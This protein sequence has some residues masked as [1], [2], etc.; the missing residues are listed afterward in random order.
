[1]VHEVRAVADL[2]E[3]VPVVAVVQVARDACALGLPVEPGAERAVVDA[4]AAD[5]D[6]DR[7]VQLDAGDLVAVELAL[8]GD[9]VDVVVLDRGEH[10][11][12]VADDAFL[13]AVEDRVAPD[14]VRADVLAVPADLAGGEHGLELVLVAGF[15]AAQR[16]VIVACRGLLAERDSRAPRV[17]DRV[18][19]D[20]PALGPVRADEPGLVRGR[21]GPRARRLGQFEAAYGDVVE[22]VLGRIEHRPAHVDLHQFGVRV[23]AA[24]VRPDRRRVVADLGVPD[25]AG[26]PGVA[27]P[28]GH[29]GPVVGDLG[30]QWRIGHLVAGTH[31]I[32]ATAVQVDIAEVLDGR[33][34]GLDQPVARNL[35]REGIPV[36][37]HRVGHR[38]PPHRVSGAGA[39]GTGAPGTGAPG[40]GARI[41]L[42]ARDR[43]RPLDHHVLTRRGLVGDAPRPAQ[44][45]TPRPHPLRYTPPVNQHSIAR[46][47]ELSRPADRPQRT[48]RGTVRRIRTVNRHMQY[49]HRPQ[50]SSVSAFGQLSAAAVHETGGRSMVSTPS[51]RAALA[52]A[53]GVT[54]SCSASVFFA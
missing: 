53:A 50:S 43:L 40:A 54:R 31:L 9:V 24:E 3:Q 25:E 17:V 13:P 48:T 41:A 19:L 15:V 23:G 52:L 33:R 51:A 1:M 34:P 4:V 14:H 37:E 35:E 12:E 28:A 27:D 38:R 36:A 32:A 7:G 29:A 5:L 16:R 42:P 47:G 2:D 11:A 6:V 20:D 22:V 8:E 10:A 21:R 26:L 39:P 46:P 30:A 18:V 49:R 44:P 45:A